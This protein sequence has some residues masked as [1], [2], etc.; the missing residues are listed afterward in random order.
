MDAN[1]VE[2]AEP[3]V[4]IGDVGKQTSKSGDAKKPQARTGK[5]LHVW[6]PD[7]LRDAIDDLA[8]ENRRPLTE[9]VKIAL[10]KHLTEAGKW[11]PKD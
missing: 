4:T 1:S 11:P 6:I 7:E 2:N 8:T 10:E 3:V 9:E 5:P